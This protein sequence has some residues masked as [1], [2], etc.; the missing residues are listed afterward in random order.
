[1]DK[2]KKFTPFSSKG[3]S[4]DSK[5]FQ[6]VANNK[7]LPKNSRRRES[8]GTL[9][10]NEQ[11]RKFNAQKSKTF[12]KRPKPKGQYYG[13]AKEDTKVVT[14]EKAE[15]GSVMVPGSKK[16]NLNHLLNFHYES[17]DARRTF[18]TWSYSRNHYGNTRN[19]NRWLSPVEV[20]KYNKEEFLQASCQF[21][22]TANG[23]YSL[24]LK[25]PDIL[26]DWKLI[27]QIKVYNSESLYCPICLYPPVAAKMTRCGHVYCWHCILHYLALADEGKRICPICAI[28]IDKSSLKSVVEIKQTALNVGDTVVMRLMRREKG[29][30]LITPVLEEETPIPKN[31]L[32]VTDNEAHLVFSKLLIA[33]VQYVLDIIESERVQL[34]LEMIDNPDSLENCFIGEALTELTKREEELLKMAK[35]LENEEDISKLRKQKELVD[36]TKGY[37]NKGNNSELVGHKKLGMGSHDAKKHVEFPKQKN[38]IQTDHEIKMDDADTTFGVESM[39]EKNKIILDVEKAE[40]ITESNSSLEGDNAEEKN[41]INFS[42][43]EITNLPSEDCFKVPEQNEGNTSKFTYFYQAED[44]QHLYLHRINVDMLKMQYGSL[45][46]SPRVL[47]GKILEKEVTVIHETMRNNLRYLRHLPLVCDFNWAE[48]ELKPPTISYEVL[49]SFQEELKKRQRKRNSS[50]REE[51]KRERK[52]TEEENKKMGIYPAANVDIESHQHFPEWQVGSVFNEDGNFYSESNA[53]SITEGSPSSSTLEEFSVLVTE[54][55]NSSE[56]VPSF[57]DMLRNK[58]SLYRSKSVWPSVNSVQSRSSI[59]S[60]EE[61]ECTSAPSYSQSFANALA[62]TPNQITIAKTPE[63]EE[64]NNSGGKKKKKK[65]TLLF[66]TGMARTS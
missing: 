25:D 13:S 33:N 40:Y 35:R 57:A 48:I 51:R 29:S 39:E 56:Q 28:N 6:D 42:N 53:S 47:I 5:K 18:G 61:D 8:V 20:H 27:E 26:V 34:N 37:D 44:G 45:E 11:Q 14:H 7:Q 16:Q 15:L 63:E 52:I 19:S 12:G 55:Q 23:D 3:T 65:P 31:F 4:T 43:L 10:K 64:S 22:V 46:N 17:R 59:P 41:L 1:M 24:Y 21:V 2:N 38:L 66:S 54:K 62:Y 60:V 58:E 49:Q 9:P 32:S 36:L 50:E 30:L